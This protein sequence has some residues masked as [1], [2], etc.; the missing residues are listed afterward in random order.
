M[1]DFADDEW[2]VKF[3]NYYRSEKMVSCV[4]KVLKTN[5]SMLYS[6]PYIWDL[7]FEAVDR[8]FKCCVLDLLA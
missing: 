4:E 1:A 6:F 7:L 8:A 3:G 5:S 2:F